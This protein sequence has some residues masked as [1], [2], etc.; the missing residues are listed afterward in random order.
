[1]LNLEVEEEWTFTILLQVNISN[2]WR[3]LRQRISQITFL[4]LIKLQMLLQILSVETLFTN[5]EA[6]GGS[7]QW[8]HRKCNIK[9]FTPW[10]HMSMSPGDLPGQDSNDM[11]S[12]TQKFSELND[13]TMR[14]SAILSEEC[15]VVSVEV[16]GGDDCLVSALDGFEGCLG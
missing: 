4:H 3:T 8:T 2:I 14:E 13:A 9:C 16:L 6:L 12:F 1:M 15:L 7:I 10:S 5:R 11:R